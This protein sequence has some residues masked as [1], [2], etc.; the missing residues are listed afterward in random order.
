MKLALI[1]LFSCAPFTQAYL[2]L[3]FQHWFPRY[4]Q[5]WIKAA[6]PCQ[7]QLEHYWQNNRTIYD[8][9]CSSA[10]DCI[11][12]N[13]PGTIQSN[14][15][16][17]QILLGLLPAILVNLGPTIAEVA[18]LS[19]YKPLLATLLALGSPAVNIARV[20]RHIDVKEPFTQPMSKTSRVWSTW[21]ARQNVV[22]RG[23]LRALSYV[24]ALA[25]IANNIWNSVYLDLRTI[26]GW[27]CGALLM[28]LVWSL[29][30]VV[31]HAWGMAAIRVQSPEGFRP[32]IRSAV[33]TTA[34]RTASKGSEGVLSEMLLW[35][36]SLFAVVHLSFGVF[37][38]S[39]L[40]FVSAPEA[41]EIFL[42]FALSA[43]LC[44]IVVKMELGNMRCE[45]GLP[46]DVA[47]S[48]NVLVSTTTA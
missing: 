18:V 24:A 4:E 10:A 19:T 40:V 38:L 2:R 44:Q 36:G 32:S 46:S 45:M 1:V 3:K 33:R 5:R 30:A 21:S 43:V 26:S 20:F 16:S 6:E 47:S 25:A 28:P 34:F 9:P 35:V 23:P 8:T 48:P 7:Q 11:L 13:I 29:L 39:S 27:R 14:F 12:Q 37:V 31:V 42:R 41:I 15:N 17:A 22:L